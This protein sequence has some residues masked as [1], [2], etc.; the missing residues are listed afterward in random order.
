MAKKIITYILGFVLFLTLFITLALIVFSNTVL[1]KQFVLNI[2]EESN[3]YE[4][5]Y[6]NIKD[7]FE[8][9]IIQS[10]ID[11]K[12]LEGIY[13][14][15]Q[16]KTD[17][18]SLIDAIYEEKEIA[19][20]SKIIAEKIDSIINEILEENNRVP[21]KEEKES[22]ELFEKNMSK[23]YEQNIVYAKEYIEKINGILPKIQ[24]YA[25]KATIAACVIDIVIVFIIAIINRNVKH[26]IKS[27]GVSFVATGLLASLMLPLIENRIQN[28][29]IL[30]KAFSNSLIM[31]VNSVVN[32]FFVTGIVIIVIGSVAIVLSNVQNGR[33]KMEE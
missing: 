9:Y 10:G 6:Y 13:S 25:Q 31:L 33:R 8:S 4:N 21:G 2:L 5:T 20:D 17:I 22:I 30:N 28:I 27:L 1:K 3:Y 19:V 18:N 7:E 26:T 29:L 11:E 32:I 12:D 14:L 16:V 15:E 24:N 23:V